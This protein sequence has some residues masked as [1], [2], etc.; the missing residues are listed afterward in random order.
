MMAR[1]AATLFLSLAGF[2]ASLYAFYVRYFQWRDCFNELGRCY[3]PDGSRQVYTTAGQ[4]WG[5]VALAFLVVAVAAV[6][7]MRSARASRRLDP[8]E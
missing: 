3:D 5:Y 6:I 8:A 7:Q 2:A 1:I 4:V